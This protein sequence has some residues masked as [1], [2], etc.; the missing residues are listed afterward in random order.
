MD[1]SAGTA[2]VDG[3]ERTDV[4]HHSFMGAH[5]IEQLEGT[6]IINMDADRQ[7][8][9]AGDTVTLNAVLRN[10]LSGH[11]FPTGS[12]EERMLWLEVW[13]TD[14]EGNRYSNPVGSKGFEG[15]E[16][17]IADSSAV[18]YSDI[19]DIRK[20]PD[21]QGCHADGTSPTAPASSATRSS[22]PKGR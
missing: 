15:E 21:L 16:Y 8:A 20:L 17:T 13:A 7:Q 14:S 1:F 12:T 9:S 19:G 3:K 22:I 2:A 6:V 10:V 5:F 18:A 4:A 11:Y